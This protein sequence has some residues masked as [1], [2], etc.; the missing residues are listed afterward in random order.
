MQ[1]Q[2]V[3]RDVLGLQHAV[4]RPVLHPVPE[5]LADEGRVDGA[6]DD[7]MGHVDSLRAE[8][9]SHALGER[10]QRELGPGEG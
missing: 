4:A 9:A 1:H 3:R 8:L 7:H 5:V 10:A 6:V 2:V